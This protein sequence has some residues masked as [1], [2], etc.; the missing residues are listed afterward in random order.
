M[1]SLESGNQLRGVN[2]LEFY[3]DFSDEKL[4]IRIF[5]YDLPDKFGLKIFEKT[6]YLD[7]KINNRL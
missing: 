5:R 3:E 7:A 4:V 1:V 2:N 6:D